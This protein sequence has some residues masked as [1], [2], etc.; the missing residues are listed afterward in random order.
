MKSRRIST[1]EVAGDT[2]FYKV[3]GEGTPLLLIAGGGGDGDLYLPLADALADSFMIITYDRRANARSS[4]NHPDQ[5]SVFQQAEDAVAI[6][7]AVGIQD[8]YVFGNSSGAVIALE[9]VRRFPERVKGVIA[10]EPP[11]AK[12]H[13]VA[14]KWR[15]FFKSCYQASFG[16][17]GA[18]WAASKFLFGIEVPVWQ[19]IS[20]QLSAQK[21]VKQEQSQRDDER[22]P[23]KQA[24]QYLIRQ[25]LLPVTEYELDFDC[26][27]EIT[28]PVVIAVGTYAQQH[29]TF[30][31]QIGEQLC[32]RLNRTCALL[33]GH[34]GS[35]MDDAVN[36][37][38]E[39]VKI[40]EKMG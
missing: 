35:F 17:G 22:I 23:S 30:L 9:M 34:H 10:H 26:F 11:L 2:L 36:W 15:R 40:I 33:P 16:R 19:M 4:M 25:E 18:S 6:L 7:D 29:N 8:A 24:T 31:Y 14:D 1:I 32:N 37:A 39:I 5:F 21:Y 20:A 27:L 28:K 38:V 3:T 13:P 12:V